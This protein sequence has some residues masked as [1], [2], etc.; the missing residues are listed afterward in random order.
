MS[1]F[2]SLILRHNPGAV[3]IQ[4]ERVGAWANV[5]ELMNGINQTGRHFIDREILEKIVA[6]D[7]KGRY[8]FNEDGTKVRANQGHSIDVVLDMEKRTPPEF[9]YHGTARNFLDSIWVHGLLP[10]SRNFVHLSPD[11]ETAVT[12][13][14]RHSKPEKPVVLKIH[15]GQMAADGYEF[16]ISDNG[17][18]QIKKVPPQYLEIVSRKSDSGA[19]GKMMIRF[20]KKSDLPQVNANRR[21]VHEVHAEGRPDIFRRKFGKK[22]ANLIDDMYEDAYTK[23][24]VADMEGTIGGFAVL[25]MIEKPKS[26]YSK[27]RCYLR[28]TE[29]GVDESY[30]RQGI[31]TALMDFIKQ[32]AAEQDFD[33]VELDVWEFNEG[34]RQFYESVGFQTYRRYMEYKA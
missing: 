15:A 1:R 29:F 2:I 19:K 17:V 25:E 24:V 13:G 20:A 8:S 32:Y 31:G 16:M 28:V 21:Q 11:Y 14:Y 22:L 27:A 10:R 6:E 9:L 34:A 30:R 3:G 5:D 4:I 26:P 33:T 23:I 18:W 7:N 12:V